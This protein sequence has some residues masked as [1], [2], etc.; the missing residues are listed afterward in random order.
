MRLSVKHS[1]CRG[2]KKNKEER[3]INPRDDSSPQSDACTFCLIISNDE[4]S[5]TAFEKVVSHAQS[6]HFSSLQFHPTTP[7]CKLL[8]P[9]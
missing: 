7:N 8:V 6:S 9:T 2:G 1:I 5:N 3:P 4:V